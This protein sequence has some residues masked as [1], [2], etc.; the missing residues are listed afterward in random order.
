MS[1]GL[2]TVAEAAAALRISRT[3]LYRLFAAGELR[4]VQIGAHRRITATE[5]D[6]FI[7]AHTQVAS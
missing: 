2:L 4:W 6:R 5:I 3:S 7:A 1:A